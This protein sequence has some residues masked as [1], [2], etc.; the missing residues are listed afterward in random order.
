M[1]NKMTRIPLKVRPDIKVFVVDD[2]SLTRKVLCDIITATPGMSVAGTA[3]NGQEALER[4]PQAAPDIVCTDFHMPVMD[5]GE[6]IRRLMQSNPLPVL[7]VSI[8]VQANETANIFQLLEAGALDVIAKPRMTFAGGKGEM[9]QVA[10]E[11]ISKIRILSGVYVFRRRT[12]NVAANVQ[13]AAVKSDA[14]MT[15]ALPPPT[16]VAI[17]ASTG[18]PQALKE[19]LSQ[20]KHPLAFPVVCVQ[21]I[22]AGFQEGLLS[23]LRNEIAHPVEVARA[24]RRPCAGTVYFSAEG[25]HLVFDSNGCF[26][27]SDTAPVD[28]I[29]PAIDLLFESAVG[30]YGKGV[31]GILLS[32][33]GRDG[34][35]GMKHIVDGGGTTV[36][37][38]EESCV[39]FGMPKAAVELGAAHFSLAPKQIAELLNATSAQ[40]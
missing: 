18:G 11:L 1:K 30:P 40:P 36:A 38:N 6:L 21:H 5:G 32:G 26:S 15:K 4:I 35:R 27:Y 14:L 23:W 39:V 12:G 17:G 20:L 7:V 37:Q 2:S 33:M 3:A 19:V 29:R 22:S 8:S 31:Y 13:P 9:Q 16:L 24:G 34:A 10:N 28:G 25:R